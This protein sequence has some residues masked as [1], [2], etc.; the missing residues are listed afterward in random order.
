MGYYPIFLDIS[1]KL[2]VVVGGGAVAERKAQSLLE[3]GA[4][5]RLISPA[6]TGELRRLAATG[7]INAEQRP[8]RRGD[9]SGA[10]VAIVATDDRDLN[11]QAAEEA[12]SAGV[13]VNVVDDPQQSTFIV[14][15][16]LSRGDISIAISTGGK[17][18]ALSKSMRLLLERLL[19]RELSELA[20]LVA[21]VREE[22]KGRGLDGDAWQR[23][24]DLDS[25]LP[26]LR[27]GNRAGARERLMQG[28]V[29][30]EVLFDT[31][32]GECNS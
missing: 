1:G 32:V 10:A 8:Y 22:L 27:Q 3:Q 13:L 4:R 17:S 16:L 15:S 31:E 30:P 25:L 28:L 6:L 7:A 9:L 18:P 21:E 24:L 5:V 20:S 12:R 11:R 19:P 26:M 23:A 2:C 14:P 29:R